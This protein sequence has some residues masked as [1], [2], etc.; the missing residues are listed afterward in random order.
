MDF[1][2]LN[3]GKSDDDRQGAD[4]IS[5]GNNKTLNENKNPRIRQ[6][7][8]WFLMVRMPRLK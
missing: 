8:S 4:H 5:K 1:M 3:V 2:N 7:P 6:S